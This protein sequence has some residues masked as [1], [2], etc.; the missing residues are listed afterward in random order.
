MDQKTGIYSESAVSAV[1]RKGQGFLE[2]RAGPTQS[3]E[4]SQENFQRK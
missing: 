3:T 4:G 2:S 1:M